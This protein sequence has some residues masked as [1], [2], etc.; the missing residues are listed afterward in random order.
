MT[1]VY[2]GTHRYTA[3]QPGSRTRPRKQQREPACRHIEGGGIGNTNSDNYGENGNDNDDD[4]DDDDDN[5]CH[6]TA[7][8]SRPR[9]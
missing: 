4:D 9:F 7:K 2:T 6:M 3:Q 8:L 1:Y 5:P